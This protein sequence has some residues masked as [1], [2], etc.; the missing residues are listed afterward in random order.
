MRQR[1]FASDWEE[2]VQE[3][4]K[5]KIKEKHLKG[6]QVD[7][8][9]DRVGACAFFNCFMKQKFKICNGIFKFRVLRKFVW[10]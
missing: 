9:T 2:K 7:K 6:K 10:F 3:N 1:R 5:R 4:N 8:A